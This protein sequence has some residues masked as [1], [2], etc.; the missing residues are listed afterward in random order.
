M[1]FIFDTNDIILFQGDSITD[2]GRHKLKRTDLGAGYV[3]LINHYIQTHMPE[4]SILCYNKGVY[5]NR[6]SE[7]KWRW[8]RDCLALEPT[9]LSLLIGINDTWRN[10]DLHITTSPE[11]FR[12]NYL[13]LIQSVKE[14]MPHVQL[15]LMSP[16]LLPIED[17]QLA[18]FEDLN[19][20]IDIVKSIAEQYDAI[21][22]PL[23]EIFNEAVTPTRPHTYWTEDG[24]HPTPEGHSLIAKTWL[25]YTAKQ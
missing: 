13:Y 22:I 7:L 25:K 18:W 2:C 24:V 14:K 20:K 23:E 8:Q 15:V 4:K 16:F 17:S 21:Y 12:N 5:G 11:R 1:N 19:P 6:T 3:N 9:I 10:Y